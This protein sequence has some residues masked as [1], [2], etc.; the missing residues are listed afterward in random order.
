VFGSPPVCVEAEHFCVCFRCG[1]VG[2]WVTGC[3][4][5]GAWA[6]E[7]SDVDKIDQQFEAKQQEIEDHLGKSGARLGEEYVQALSNLKLQY[8]K[9]GALA[10][11]LAVGNEI[12][13]FKAEGTTSNVRPANMPDKVFAAQ[14]KY[15]KSSGHLEA[16]KLAIMKTLFAKHLQSIEALQIKLAK[17]DRVDEALTLDANADAVKT[18]RAALTTIA[19]ETLADVQA[20]IALPVVKSQGEAPL[21]LVAIRGKGLTGGFG[22]I[23]QHHNVPYIYTNQRVIRGGKNLAFYTMGN[24]RI[25]VSKLELAN[26]RDLVRIHFDPASTPDAKALTIVT[27]DPTIEATTIQFDAADPDA[28]PKIMNGKLLAVGP[29]KIELSTAFQNEHC[30]SPILNNRHQVVGVASFVQNRDSESWINRGTRF[31][32]ERHF[33]YRI[34]DRINWVRINAKE[35]YRL[36]GML[37]DANLFINELAGAF[38]GLEY[39]RYR[40]GN[41]RTYIKTTYD[42]DA[43]VELYQ[44]KAYPQQVQ[45]LYKKFGRSSANAKETSDGNVKQQDLHLKGAI[46]SNA[47]LAKT[48]LSRQKWSHQMFKEEAKFLTDIAGSFGEYIDAV[49]E[50]KIRNN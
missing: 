28:T 50:E 3:L 49:F 12:E 39:T 37:S 6:V 9:Q 40:K 32:R 48:T 7:P 45:S 43:S 23:G 5:G 13:R 22:F 26:K 31:S 19:N 15:R 18:Q 25:R 47:D 17:E 1:L 20:H 35:F 46:V 21:A 24:K 8:R 10:Q 30:G 41:S 33:G 42:Y 29:E 27:G 44:N 36:G 14:Q 11:V 4:I 34:D 38:R 16:K 2:L